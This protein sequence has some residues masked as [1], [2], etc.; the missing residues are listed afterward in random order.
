M[1]NTNE[2]SAP[3]VI[4]S[5]CAMPNKTPLIKTDRLIGK[6]NYK[7]KFFFDI[8]KPVGMS[9]KL[10]DNKELYKLGWSPKYDL[11]EGI[12]ET[13]QFFNKR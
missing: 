7:G 4:I 11:N 2:R 6:V 9:N 3:V 13:V 1:R 5:K 12:S 8:T 10:M